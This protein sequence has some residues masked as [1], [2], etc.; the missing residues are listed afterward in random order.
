MSNP[1]GKMSNPPDDIKRLGIFGG[2]FDP[3]H[4]GHLICAEQL[5]EALE[6]DLVLLVP[7][8]SPPHK[9]VSEPADPEHRL[10]MVRL[11]I[12]GQEGL[13][14][15]DVEIRRGGTS[16]TIDTI[17]D[18]RGEYGSETEFWL[19]M[20]Q[21]SY[22]DISAWKQPAG[23]VA[24]CFF[25]IAR[26]PGYERHIGPPVPGIRSRFVDITAVDI[27]STDIRARISEARSIRFLV[28]GK[29]EEYIRSNRVYAPA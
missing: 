23:I 8:H 2:T 20:G 29:V 13:Q 16:Y 11:A 15:S 1:V 4:F 14:A 7:T 5:R 17:R 19:L 22:H 24:E 12:E 28:P 3:I 26:R 18:L 25:G 27:S 6:L 10:A 21:D 9:P